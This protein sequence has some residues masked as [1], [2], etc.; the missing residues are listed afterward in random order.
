MTIREADYKQMIIA[1]PSMIEEGF[2]IREVEKK[3]ASG[4]IDI[5]GIDTNQNFVVVELKKGSPDRKVIGQITSYI[6]A[7]MA[8]GIPKHKLRG[9]IF[10]S[11]ASENLKLAV[12]ASDTL[13]LIEYIDKEYRLK[14][15]AYALPASF[16]LWLASHEQGQGVFAYD[17]ATQELQLQSIANDTSQFQNKLAKPVQSKK[18]KK[19]DVFNKILELIDRFSS[20][21]SAVDITTIR[22]NLKSWGVLDAEFQT[23]I[24]ELLKHGQIFQPKPGQVSLSY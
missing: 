24:N 22:S 23:Y 4:Y 19:R 13:E 3:V 1:N 17:E 2:V 11:K 6:G 15:D 16:K 18:L 8:S 21:Q 5:F 10:C 14:L 20:S 9:I 7:L 12:Q